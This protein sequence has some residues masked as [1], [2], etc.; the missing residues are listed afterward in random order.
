[1]QRRVEHIVQTVQRANQARWRID[2]DVAVK[3]QAAELPA[4]SRAAII[5]VK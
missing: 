4:A 1:M 5:S 2:G 3:A